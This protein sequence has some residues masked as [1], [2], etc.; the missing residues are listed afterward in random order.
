MQ[1]MELTEDIIKL[2]FKNI[3]FKHIFHIMKYNQKK[4]TLGFF[5]LF[6][7]PGR[8][9]PLLPSFFSLSNCFCFF[10]IMAH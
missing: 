7:A 5:A 8:R 1:H 2:V 4:A 10:F 3:T 6:C 9:I